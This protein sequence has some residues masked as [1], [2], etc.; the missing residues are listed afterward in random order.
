[1]QLCFIRLID[2]AREC[3]ACGRCEISVFACFSHSVQD[4][5]PTKTKTLP[6]IYFQNIYCFTVYLFI[7]CVWKLQTLHKKNWKLLTFGIWKV[8][9][10]NVFENIVE[11]DCHNHNHW[12]N[13]TT[14]KWFNFNNSTSNAGEKKWI[15]G[16]KYVSTKRISAQ[17]DSICTVEY[18]LQKFLH[19]WTT[20][21]QYNAILDL[22]R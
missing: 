22:E 9:T 13:T 17:C 8:I 5:E 21:C 11:F 19:V 3:N 6:S 2:F 18:R 16:T 7:V 20:V 12:C 1:M 10:Q 15:C 4:K 14:K